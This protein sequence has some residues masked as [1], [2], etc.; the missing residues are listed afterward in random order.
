MKAILLAAGRGTRLGPHTADK[1]KSLIKLGGITLLER[2]VGNLKRT[3]FEKVVIVVGYRH[4]M[5]EAVLAQNFPASFYKVIMNPDYTRGSASSLMCAHTEMDGEVLTVES[6]LLY[7]YRI[8]L[9]MKPATA[10]N[11]MAMGYFN[12]GRKEVKVYL[13]QGNH[14]K[15]AAW[16][17][18]SDTE[19]A[20]DWV[21]FTRFSAPATAALRKMIEETDL[22][23]GKEL[24]Y[25]EFV[26]KL[27]P[28]FSF[29]TMYIQDLPWIEIDNETDLNRAEKEVCP[30][31][32]NFAAVG[33]VF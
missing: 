8:L 17:E 18:A 9:R 15:R 20:G 2:C 4:E 33:N 1:P 6:D 14:I 31:I 29:Q 26:F 11:A 13:D 19:A 7:D 5:I 23:K 16:A 3:G 27:I 25:E 32:D 30:K 12:H 22:E 28:Q 10:G 24:G 21:G